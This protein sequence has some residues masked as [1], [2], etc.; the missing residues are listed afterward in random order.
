MREAPRTTGHL[1]R[2]DQ[3]IRKPV[4]TPEME[5]AMVGMRR[6]RP[7]EVADSRRTAWKKMGT[8]KRMAL[9][10]TA[11]R[12]LEKMRLERGECVRRRSGMMGRKAWS[13]A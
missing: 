2:R 8:L 10:T 6:C 5:A 4:L 3:V 7:E 9:M 1:R 12:K 11:E 13:S